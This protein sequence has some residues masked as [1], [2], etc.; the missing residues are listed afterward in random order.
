M[1]KKKKKKCGRSELRKQIES[2][3]LNIILEELD[4]GGATSSKFDSA[5]DV[6]KAGIL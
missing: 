2:K 6:L 1:K 4:A 3:C 5:L